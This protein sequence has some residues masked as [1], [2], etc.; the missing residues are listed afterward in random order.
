MSMT[1]KSIP[2]ALFIIVATII[3]C[4][5]GWETPNELKPYSDT[6]IVSILSTPHVYES[7][8]VRV[9]GM[10]W[11]I[12]PL[13]SKTEKGKNNNEIIKFKLSD[14]KGYYIEVIAPRTY[15]ISEGDIVEVKGIFRTRYKT[16][17]KVSKHIE[18]KDIKI[19][20][21]LKKKYNKPKEEAKKLED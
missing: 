20:K 13:E 12:E 8:A 16:D 4:N 5:K 11:S 7:T 21:S 2:L 6:K 15:N 3:S 19:I 18:T 10:V 17:S 1:A 9:K 14:P